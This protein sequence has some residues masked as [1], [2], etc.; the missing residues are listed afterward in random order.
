MSSADPLAGC[1]EK[2]KRAEFHLHSLKPLIDAFLK[3]HPDAYRII[4]EVDEKT[5]RY[6]GRVQ[7]RNEPPLEWSVV[8]GD[9]LHNLRC[10]LDHVMRQLVI[11]NGE[12]PTFGN[13]FPIF[14]Q[15]PPEDPC[16]GERQ[17]WDRNVKGISDAALDFVKFCQPYKALDGNPAAHTLA[18]LRRLSNEDKHRTLI[19]SLLALHG[20]PKFFSFDLVEVVNIRP[21]SD[22]VQ[23]HAGRP[24]KD[25][26]VAFHA[27]VTIT[28]PNPKVKAKYRFPLDIGFGDPPV[29]LEGLVQMR[30]L[31]RI[32]LDRARQ[33]LRE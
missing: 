29:P 30:D 15:E 11:A 6:V 18:G 21:P 8:V 24:L 28:G 33:L 25:G 9:A 27:P 5:S 13:A 20:D 32:V 31:G 1:E 2:L 3:E 7:I 14:D 22:K 4:P 23:I 19:P 16:N 17:R 10:V 26:D 12:R